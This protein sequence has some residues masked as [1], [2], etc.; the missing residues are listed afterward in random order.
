VSVGATP[1]RG[2]EYGDLPIVSEVELRGFLE[3]PLARGTVRRSVGEFGLSAGRFLKNCLS[4]RAGCLR[5]P[6]CARAGLALLGLGSEGLGRGQLSF[7]F[8]LSESN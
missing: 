6:P 8:F 4:A 3:R 1:E 2:E 5:G 7:L